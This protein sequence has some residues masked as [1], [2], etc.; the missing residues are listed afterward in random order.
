MSA[1]LSPTRK[2]DRAK[3]AEQ[4]AAFVEARGFTAT[5]E[6]PWPGEGCDEAMVRIEA[7]GAY[8]GVTIGPEDAKHGY[9]TPWNVAHDNSQRFTSAFG[10]A[11]RSEVNPFHRRKCMGF[12]SDFETL[13]HCIGRALD[14][15]TDGEAF[16]AA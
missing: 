6:N 8:V 11:V 7:G 13:L 5:I 16:Q 4:L 10:R 12:A 9:C 15:I 3:L 1:A 2:A 14:C